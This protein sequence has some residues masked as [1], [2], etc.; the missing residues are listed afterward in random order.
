MGWWLSTPLLPVPGQPGDVLHVVQLPGGP[1]P[2]AFQRVAFH[3]VSGL[4]LMEGHL[5]GVNVSFVVISN[6]Y[7]NSSRQFR[8]FSAE[9]FISAVPSFAVIDLSVK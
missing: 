8:A 1:A 9:T 5:T 2:A 3:E 4:E 6:L 7:A